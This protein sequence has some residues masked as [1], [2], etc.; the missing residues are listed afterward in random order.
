MD[1][2]RLLDTFLELVTIDSPS[3]HEA[4][5]ADYCTHI[6]R[7][8]LG[9]TVTVDDAGE[10]MGSDTGNLCAVFGGSSA[11]SPEIILTAHMDSVMPCLGIKPQISD[12]VIRSD[13]STVLGSDD[14][15]GIAAILEALRCLK[16]EGGD[17]AQVCVVLTIQEEVGCCGAKAFEFTRSQE[18]VPCY[19]LDMDGTPGAAVTAA[20]FHYQLRA[21]FTGRPAHAGVE[22]EKG[23]SAIEA[24]SQAIV[25]MR[26]RGCL[27][28]IGE[29]E[30]ANI[31]TIE[32]GTADNVVPAECRLV[33]ECRAFEREA[34]ETIVDSMQACLQEAADAYGA[35]LE[36]DWDN[37]FSGFSLDDTSP[38]VELFS[39]AVTSL[40]LTPTFQTSTGCSDANVFFESGPE[41]LV[42]ATG[43]T[44]FH[45]TSESLKVADLETM[46]RIVLALARE[47]VRS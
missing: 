17:H 22:P 30:T 2:Q 38:A 46:T 23:I 25:L 28:R 27:G 14:K 32:G 12:G 6:L 39:R 41:P 21:T 19:V 36:V 10:L 31:G 11:D 44:D 45:S 8:E 34:V 47:A 1:A 9:C 43:M 37:E 42:L 3:G 4:G 15:V 35:R 7:D 40:G 29:D 13:G 20:P 33:G 26:Q 16:E 5:V 18:G 24:A